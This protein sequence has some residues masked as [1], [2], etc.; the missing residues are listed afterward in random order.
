MPLQPPSLSAALGRWYRRYRR[1]SYATRPSHIKHVDNARSL[2]AAIPPQTRRHHSIVLGSSRSG[3]PRMP[4]KPSALSTQKI[5][6]LLC[7]NQIHRSVVKAHF[8]SVAAA[9]SGWTARDNR[10][11]LGVRSANAP[12]H[13]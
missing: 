7:C 3:S 4:T 9:A 12:S 1:R 2:P 6:R 10:V 11:R 5:L 8:L 13:L